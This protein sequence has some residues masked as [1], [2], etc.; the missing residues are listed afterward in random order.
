MWL[1][2]DVRLPEMLF[3][4]V[5]GLRGS[6]S[7]IMCTAVVTNLQHGSQSSDPNWTVSDAAAG[8][9]PVLRSQLA[10]MRM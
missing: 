9:R 3:I 10:G 8:L 4:C 1:Q 5:A 2:G 7:L 6:T